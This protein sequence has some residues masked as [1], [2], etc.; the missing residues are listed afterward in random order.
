MLYGLSFFQKYDQ[1]NFEKKNLSLENHQK[2]EKKGLAMTVYGYQMFKVIKT[3]LIEK[4]SLLYLVK[5]L[6]YISSW[7][8]FRARRFLFAIAKL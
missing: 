5:Q 3:T 1:P 2:F 8:V 6:S 7:G 4:K